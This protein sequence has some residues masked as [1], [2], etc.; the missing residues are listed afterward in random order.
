M[1][2]TNVQHVHPMNRPIYYA[3]SGYTSAMQDAR[4][5]I[6]SLDAR[7]SFD[8]SFLTPG[9]IRINFILSETRVLNYVAAA[10]I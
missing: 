3:H 5:S 10:I 8:A 7:L 2:Y 1:T 6:P 4:D 9:N